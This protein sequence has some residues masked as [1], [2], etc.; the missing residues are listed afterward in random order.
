MLTPATML[1]PERA[2]GLAPGSLLELFNRAGVVSAGDVHVAV[3]LSRLA[4]G[5]PEAVQLAV[6]L[7]ARAPR[8]G[9]VL[10]D[11]T[12]VSATVVPTAGQEPL[13]HPA[14]EEELDPASL[15]WPEPA[16]WAR[17]VAG[18]GLCNVGEPGSAPRP[19]VEAARPLR[20]VGQCLYLDR[21]WSDET[22]VAD[23]VVARAGQPWRGTGRLVA[24]GAGEAVGA[25]GAPGPVRP[26]AVERLFPG[27]ATGS[28]ALAALRAMHTALSVISGGPGTGKTTTVAR[29]LALVYEQAIAGAAH[30]AG[31]QEEH[32]Q[33]RLP[34]VALA[35]P[36]GKAAARMAEAVH[37]EAAKANIGDEVKAA[38][39]ALEASTVHRLLG[40]SP[41]RQDRFHHNRENQLPHDIVVVDETSMMSLPLMA[42]LLEAVRTGSRLVLVGDHEQLASVEA[43]AVLADLVGPIAGDQPVPEASPLSRSI[44]V[45][46]QNH[47]FTGPLAELAG[48]VRAGRSNEALALLSSPDASG[49]SSPARSALSDASIAWLAV[50]GTPPSA[51]ALRETVLANVGPLLEAGESGEAERGLA[52]LERWRAL[53][54]HR[55]G[56][57][58]ASTWN[59]QVEH[60]LAREGAAVP[61][62]GWYAGRPVVVTENDYSLGL[63]NG[64]SGFTVARPGGGLSVAFRRGDRVELVSPARLGHVQTAYAMTAHRAQGSE[65]D[66]VCVLLPDVPARVLTRELVYTALT[67]ARLGVVVAATEAALVSAIGRPVARASRLTERTWGALLER[68]GAAATVPGN[69]RDSGA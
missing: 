58:G 54:T 65:F 55:D 21:Y 4:G 50:A 64:D 38:L 39:M 17:A 43:G 32:E 24:P 68:P 66:R 13:G 12:E 5:V 16:E 67:R 41:G 46:K 1:G 45:L 47:R 34:L 8:M 44:T 27:E 57:A 62:G 18:S 10:V 6:A 49:P 52:V 61:V 28:Q 23:E 48:H 2:Y 37:R 25:P 3:V 15:P 42:R 35:A 60:W 53:C 36:T 9:H 31:A 69:D 7:A 51:A 26:E 40:R 22:L 33:A 30:G 56:P 59:E 29:F 63:F 11:L 19:S 20:L 14:V